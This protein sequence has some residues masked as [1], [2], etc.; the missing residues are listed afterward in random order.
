M[1]YFHMHENISSY[2]YVH[3]PRCEHMTSMCKMYKS[4][5]ER[6]LHDFHYQFVGWEVCVSN[7]FSTSGIRQCHLLEHWS[8]INTVVTP[9]DCPHNIQYRLA[10]TTTKDGSIWPSK[11]RRWYS[12]QFHMWF[13]HVQPIWLF[14]YN[15]IWHSTFCTCKITHPTFTSNIDNVVYYKYT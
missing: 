12:V 13:F 4:M 6:F 14:N 2:L 7:I 10:R 5:K 9:K 3:H 11:V 15:I 8:Q 1:K